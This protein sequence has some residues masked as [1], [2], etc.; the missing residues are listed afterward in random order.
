MQTVQK[1]LLYN[2]SS[3]AI[4]YFDAFPTYCLSE[5]AVNIL[6]QKYIFK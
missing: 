6:S 2:S 3:L 4:H 5:L 1:C